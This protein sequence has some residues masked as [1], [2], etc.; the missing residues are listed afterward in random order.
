VSR[1]RASRTFWISGLA[2]LAVVATLTAL[3]YLN[4]ARHINLDFGYEFGNIAAALA[5]GRGF[6][7]PH[8]T[9]SGPTAWM[10]PMLCWIMAAVF[11]LLGVKT[12]AAAMLLAILKWFALA[13][14]AALLGQSGPA[15]F[16]L[17]WLGLAGNLGWLASDLSDPWLV[18][19]V[20][21]W[22]LSGRSCRPAGWLAALSAPL[23]SPALAGALCVVLWLRREPGQLAA[24]LLVG[25]LWC[26]R[27]GCW[28][29]IW[30]PIK[31]N[32]GFEFYQSNGL[33]SSGLLSSEVLLSHHP[34]MGGSPLRQQF[35]AQGEARFCRY[36]QRLAGEFLWS[37]PDIWLLKVGRRLVN[38][39]VCLQDP[40]D[41]RLGSGLAGEDRWQLE[42][43]RLV[44]TTSRGFYWLC[45]SS[46]EERFVQQLGSLQLIDPEGVLQS[47]KDAR[48]RLQQ[49]QNS[50]SARLWGFCFAGLPGLALL[51][52]WARGRGGD[53]LF[54]EAAL[55]YLLTLLPYVLISHYAR[56]QLGLLPLQCC[57][58]GLGLRP[59]DQP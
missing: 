51:V 36:Y 54:R 20:A 47:W 19:L 52:G 4:P 18:M 33:S 32:G 15:L 44:L 2:S 12:F 6:S 28:V 31:S 30:V 26:L 29:G 48:S 35:R 14:T 43:A 38:A 7:D 23:V 16:V 39:L 42:E 27:G 8:A 50:W 9:D 1:L 37:Q 24:L 11:W 3:A 46:S 5:E 41:V 25:G 40:N 59:R 34:L 45:L 22:A 17:F 55:L 10:A 53:P 56:Y 57:L 58:V 49:A 21:A 13:A